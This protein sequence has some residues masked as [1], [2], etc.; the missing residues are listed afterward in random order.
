[1]VRQLETE[2]PDGGVS[3]CLDWAIKRQV[4]AAHLR[5]HGFTWEKLEQ[6][7]HLTSLLANAL[8]SLRPPLP[9]SVLS[10]FFIRDERGP[11]R[12]VIDQLSNYLAER[13]LCWNEIDTYFKLRLE[14]FEIDTRFG[15][16]G[17]G[18]IFELFNNAGALRHN[19]PGV[20]NID[21]AIE[22]PPA[23]GRAKLRAA[24]IREFAHRRAE[25]GCDWDSIHDFVNDRFLDMSD[26]W[27]DQAE[28]HAHPGNVEH[29]ISMHRFIAMREARRQRMQAPHVPS[30]LR[31]Q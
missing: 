2:G 1:M 4:F 9:V 18:G 5:K 27:A 16:L 10:A 22:D 14:L 25:M 17:G 23:V 31:G 30:P 21:Q 3:T 11:L 19:L 13:Q 6:W 24:A 28:W 20:E 15:E 12:S 29:S 7:T 26:P 8:A